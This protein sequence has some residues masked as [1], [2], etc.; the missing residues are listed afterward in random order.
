MK[1][2]QHVAW[3]ESNA[4]T[5]LEFDGRAQAVAVELAMASGIS[6][7]AQL[8]LLAHL[9]HDGLAEGRR[10]SCTAL[11]KFDGPQADALVREALDDPDAGVQAAAVRQLRRRSFPDALKLLVGFL[12]SCSIE[13]RDTA[14]SSLAEFNYVRYRAMFDLLDDKAARSTGTLVHKVDYSALDGL[15]EDLKSPSVSTRL[16]A[17]EMAIAMDAADDVCQQLIALAKSDNLPVRRE[18]VAALGHC[19]EP[20]ALEE[21]R[22][23]ANDP[24]ETIREVAIH[25]LELAENHLAT[26]ASGE[27]T[28]EYQ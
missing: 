14:R 7:D 5:L 1:R 2:L 21:L 10:A 23:A 26:V 18:A 19:I 15:V 4:E 13:V 16:R 3:L 25:A 17:I 6:R 28:G 22:A 9:L 20:S 12:D 24:H 8:K 27:A 11:E